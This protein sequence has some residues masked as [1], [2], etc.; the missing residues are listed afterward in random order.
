M[1]QSLDY[2]PAYKLV[3]ITDVIVKTGGPYLNSLYTFTLH[4]FT[5]N[6]QPRYMCTTMCNGRETD[7]HVNSAM[8]AAQEQIRHLMMVVDWVATLAGN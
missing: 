4:L 1:L 5:I 2:V 7:R 6:N 8:D 3:S